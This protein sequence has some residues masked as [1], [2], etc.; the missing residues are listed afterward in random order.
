MLF[1]ILGLTKLVILVVG[2][3][4][5]VHK[6]LICLYRAKIRIVKVLKTWVQNCAKLLLVVDVMWEEKPLFII[7]ITF[8]PTINSLLTAVVPHGDMFDLSQYTVTHHLNFFPKRL[9]ML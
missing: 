6:V 3:V 8:V 9:I 4:E 1:I 7:R 5:T 2:P